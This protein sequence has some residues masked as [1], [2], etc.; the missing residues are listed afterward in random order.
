MAAK[1]IYQLGN[2][3]LYRTSKEVAQEELYYVKLIVNDLHDT[4]VRFLT[5]HDF[6]RAIAAPQIGVMK[7]LV[8]LLKE[9]PMVFINPVLTFPD[10]EMMEI[11]DNCMSFPELMVKVR[12][13]KKCN[14]SY[15]NREW[16]L[17]SQDLEGD[18]SELLQHECDHLDGILAVDRAI[19]SRSFM[20]R[21]EDLKQNET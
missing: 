21:S 13:F 19:D 1:D 4:I 20:L 11:W 18:M 12:R 17:V 10:S 5:E 14:I 8:Y 6:G 3:L 2:E 9:E 7:R 15:R 16:E